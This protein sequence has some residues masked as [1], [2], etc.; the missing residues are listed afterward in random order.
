MPDAARIQGAAVFVVALLIAVALGEAAVRVVAPIHSGVYQ[1]DTV[2]L[3]TLVPSSRRRVVRQA[4]NG[5]DVIDVRIDSLG[6]RGPEFA[7]ARTSRVRR[8]AV[9]GDSD[10]EGEFMPDSTTFVRRLGRA[11]AAASHDSVEAINA[12]VVGYGTDQV[13]LRMRRELPRLAPDAV[14]VSLRDN[15]FGDL[16]RDKLFR[17]DTAAGSA[18]PLLPNPHRLS[19]VLSDALDRAAHPAGVHRL[20][21][22]RLL[23]KLRAGPRGPRASWV[24]SLRDDFGGVQLRESRTEYENTVVQRDSVVRN[25]FRDHYD[26]DIAVAPES[27]SARYKVALMGAVLRAIRDEAAA[28]GVRL[29][30]MVVPSAADACETYE[31]RVNRARHPSYDPRRLTATAER[32]AAD[33]G[34]PVVSLWDAFQRAGACALYFRFGDDHWNERAQALAATIVADELLARGWLDHAATPVTPGSPAP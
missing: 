29:V 31:F 19:G 5:G 17:V 28:R 11:L 30:V 14:V 26:A 1:P 34:I 2:L 15:D 32:L 8:I 22:W 27:A 3:H 12:G 33:A 23:E 6:F 18:P 13:L 16:L 10:I 20:M 9:F 21:L 7:L 25:L 24:D 4:G